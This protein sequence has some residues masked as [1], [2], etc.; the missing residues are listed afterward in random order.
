MEDRYYITTCL[1]ESESRDRSGD[2]SCYA[3]ELRTKF[4]P[5]NKLR[6][7][8]EISAALQCRG[9]YD[10]RLRDQSVR[11]SQAENKLEFVQTNQNL[12]IGL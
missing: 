6:T 4:D 7:P 11:V 5:G 9:D 1:S 2:W 10:Q 8:G 12:C 3:A